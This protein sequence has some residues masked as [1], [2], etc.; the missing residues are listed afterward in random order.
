MSR[1]LSVGILSALLILVLVACGGNTG[2]QE[3]KTEAS[4]N[5]PGFTVT[6]IESYDFPQA[7]SQFTFFNFNPCVIADQTVY[8]YEDGN[9][10]IC[11]S[12][13]KLAEVYPGDNLC[14][15]SAEGEI[16][17]DLPEES[18]YQT[19]PLGS[20]GL[21][22]NADEIV[23][24]TAGRK[25]RQLSKNIVNE[26]VMVLYEDGQAELFNAGTGYS[27]T[28]SLAEEETVEE[29]SGSFLRTA[30]GNVYL[31]TYRFRESDSSGSVTLSQVSTD[32]IVSISAC[33]SADR[34]IAVK[35]DGTV[36][37]YSDLE[38]ELGV[39]F[40]RIETACMGDSCCV[41]VDEDGRAHFSAYD[42]EIEEKIDSYLAGL[43]RKVIYAA[44]SDQR[45]A[46]MF[47]D[48]SVC[49]IDFI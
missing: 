40:E 1:K 44:C 28:D 45:I 16:I 35:S 42:S 37:V 34:C 30:A 8:L 48:Y 46:V 20:A 49:V 36:E 18:E 5:G 31:A 23:K 3:S 27:V 41:A 47:E 4:L 10:M 14:A 24:Q 19:Y 6:E 25:V 11:E 13:Q 32:Q 43:E 2:A 38:Q 17:A 22:Y 9:W 29:V 33:A 12:D 39:D 21:F 15:V 26:E 7:P